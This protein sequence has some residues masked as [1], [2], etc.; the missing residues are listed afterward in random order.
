M[1]AISDIMVNNV[2]SVNNSDDVHKARMLFKEKGIRHLPILSDDTA[3][4]V[5]VLTQGSLLNH[6]FNI[7]EK[8]G[9]SGLKKREQRTQVDEIMTVDCDTVAPD[10]D[11]IS[12]ANLLLTKKHSCLVVVEN[13]QLKGIVTAVDFVKLALH[14]MKA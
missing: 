8:F 3:E 5:G 6:A 2:I 4:F 14:L 13:R 12:A 11:L 7:V 10:K 1:K 9:L